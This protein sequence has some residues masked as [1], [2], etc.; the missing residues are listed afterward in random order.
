MSTP[1]RRKLPSFAWTTA[2]TAALLVLCVAKLIKSLDLTV[3]DVALPAIKS[4][5]GVSES[6]AVA[7]GQLAVTEL[8]VQHMHAV[9]V[10]H[11]IGS[12]APARTEPRLPWFMSGSSIRRVAWSLPILKT[13]TLLPGY[14]AVRPLTRHDQPCST[15]KSHF[16]RA[17]GQCRFKTLTKVYSQHLKGKVVDTAA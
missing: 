6:L 2:H 17:D 13:R 16:D 3:V 1:R 11:R 12:P 4:D 8:H 9:A 15:T 7:G 10:E 5:V 14:E